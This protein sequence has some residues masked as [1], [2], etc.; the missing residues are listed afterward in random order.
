MPHSKSIVFGFTALLALPLSAQKPVVSPGGVLNAASFVPMGEPSHA[1]T[2]GGIAS[3]FG[4]NL[5]AATVSAAASALPATLAG[6]SVT[7]NG[8]PAPLF[9][10]SPTQI[11]FQVPSS[12]DAG[13]Y[14]AYGHASIVVTTDAGSSDPAIVDTS[15]SAPGIFTVDGSGCGQGAVLNVKPDGTRS[16]NS[17]SNSASPG[18]HLEIYA[19]GAGSIYNTRGL[20]PPDGLP[21]P[22]DAVR[23][24]DCCHVSLG[25]D[26]TASRFTVNANTVFAGRAPGLIGVDQINAIIPADVRQGCAVPLRVGAFNTFSQ[27]VTVSIHSGGGQCVDSPIGSTGQLVLKRSVVLND[28][29]I[30]ETDTFSASFSASPGKTIPPPGNGFAANLYLIKAPSCPVPGYSTLSAGAITVTPPQGSPIE[31]QPSIVNGEVSYQAALPAGSVQPGVF[32]ISSNGGPDLGLFQTPIYVGAGIQITSLFP[33]GKGIG[34]G[35]VTWTG[36]QPGDTVTMNL[37]EHNFQFD[38]VWQAQAPATSGTV[39][40]PSIDF[41]SFTSSD[42]E[43]D[44]E[45]GP[46][47]S[48]DTFSLRGLTLG[49]QS[50]WVYEYRFVGL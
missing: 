48:P 44:I 15:T 39:T 43:I 8:A 50:K 37:V 47:P 19:T 7:V 21:A 28:D 4:Q 13:S 36:G 5:A 22:D 42:R 35:T 17:P 23:F 18:D 40:L 46:D 27:P 11:N 9:Y 29:T 45:V 20:G 1:V 12:T 24:G 26:T 32:Q 6:T 14:S 3:I 10:V 25:E 16:L 41:L 31:A 33:K 38:V 2:D 49:A 30:P 34:K